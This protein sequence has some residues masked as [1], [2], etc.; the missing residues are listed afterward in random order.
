MVETSTGVA[1][2]DRRTIY[3]FL[4]LRMIVA[5]F[6][7][8][9]GITIAQVTNAA[10]P[11]RPLYL[12]LAA[13]VATAALFYAALKVKAPLRTALWAMMVADIGIE[14]AIVHF[15]GGVA[16]QFS[17]VYCLTIVAAAF[18]L[19]MP[20][21]LVTAVL[22]STCYIGYGIL[23]TV[24]AV[25][26][27]AQALM[28]GRAPGLGILETYMHVSLFFLV[29]TV[30][31][32]LAHRIK[33]K[34]RAL[35]SAEN[36]LQQL[37]VDT[38]HILT[39]MSSG[40]L[41]V[42]SD[43][44]LITM[45]PAAEEILGVRRERVLGRSLAEALSAEAPELVTE[46]SEALECERGKSRH[47]VMVRTSERHAPLGTSISL[48]RDAENEKRGVIAVFTDLTEVVEM[49]ERVR[50]ADRLA[51]VGE[52]AA[53]I[54]H[55]LRN[56]LASISGSIE[57]LAGELELGGEERRLME[58]VMRESD[59]LDH[60]ISDFLEYAR[61]RPPSRARIAID[62]CLEEVLV[63]LKNNAKSEG[64]NIQFTRRGKLP[65]VRADDEQM[66]QVFMNLAVNS[67]EAMH[68]GDLE[69]VAEPVGGDWVRLAFRDT[70]PGILPEHAARLFEPFFT[71][72][73]GGTGLGLAL[74]N[75]IVE[76]HGG[77][78]EYH[79]R[80]SGGAEFV[81]M[82]P[83]GTPRRPRES[84]NED[85]EMASAAASG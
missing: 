57:V 41:V 9:A 61:L 4:I 47:E 16:S 75:R 13:S 56:P 69:I 70:G 22:S 12:L 76:A 32:Y 59:R 80:E 37:R 77:S 71:T 72:K 21:G 63:L 20:G 6:V 62:A 84:K 85:A 51:A 60:I 11:V 46:L 58:L 43:G 68:G 65:A 50:K 82:L 53:G 49:R 2:D 73:E 25:T 18:L 44:E 29:G 66:R 54:A 3:L 23:E 1:L 15:S 39:H 17:M 79:R 7:V 10:F 38:D 81:I 34:G 30:G 40:V 8:G 67:C 24:G 19:E 78:I 14:A 64:V 55:E 27:P 28:G 5:A 42:D 52:L 83:T 45:N 74:A 33:L 36:E 35:E 26:P 31:G 48:L